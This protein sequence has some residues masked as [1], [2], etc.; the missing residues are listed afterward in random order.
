M[1]GAYPDPPSYRIAWHE[2]GSNLFD[3]TDGDFLDTA[4]AE[5][6]NSEDGSTRIGTDNDPHVLAILFPDPID[7]TAI[8]L[9]GDTAASAVISVSQ[10]STNGT[11][12]TWVTAANVNGANDHN[13]VLGSGWR[14]NIASAGYPN[15][16]V[17]RIVD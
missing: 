15:V 9:N 10:N 17:L 13:A 1:A 7:L 3:I 5:A 6:L 12:G 2:D 4:T 16:K 11:D 14:D 8:W